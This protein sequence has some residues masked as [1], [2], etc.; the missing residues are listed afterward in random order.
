[1]PNIRVLRLWRWL[2]VAWVEHDHGYTS[3]TGIGLTRD[4]AM[5]RTLTAH[6]INEAS[7]PT[8]WTTADRCEH[9][10]EFCSTCSM[11]Y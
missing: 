7:K 2:W 10:N 4:S 3:A 8:M 9:G 11:E 6:T 1:M 5:H